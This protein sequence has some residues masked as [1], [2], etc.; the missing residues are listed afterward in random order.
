M[1]TN[2][3]LTLDSQVVEQ[4]EAYARAQ[5]KDLTTVLEEYLRHLVHSEK[6]AL[7]PLSP[8]LLRLRGAIQLPEGANC[9]QALA[10]AIQKRHGL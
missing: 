10:N 8:Q 7:P 6:A 1:S 2:L 5:G 4:A 3:I 9:K